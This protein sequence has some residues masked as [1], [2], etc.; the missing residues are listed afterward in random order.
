MKNTPKEID[1]KVQA[2]ADAKAKLRAEE[3]Q[4]GTDLQN[5]KAEAEAA[6]D[7]G[8]VD[9]YLSIK[10]RISRVEA[11]S[12]VRK[13][14]IEK[15]SAPVTREECDEAWATYRADYEK[16]LTKLLTVLETKRRE[17]IKA[18][19]DAVALQEQACATRER[20]GGY[21][22]INLSALVDEVPSEF[23]MMTIPTHL[24]IDDFT[25]SCPPVGALDKDL[26]YVIANSGKPKIRLNE[27]PEISH[28]IS[29]VHRGRS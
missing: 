14:Q 11:E 8:D 12:I 18:Y 27:D 6:I 2:A 3:E 10:S 16:T 9:L 20:L 15:T 1:A 21:I 23:P 25:L 5:L 17:F 29:V 22:G 26:A 24:G 4:A 7:A 28:L 19:M 13:R